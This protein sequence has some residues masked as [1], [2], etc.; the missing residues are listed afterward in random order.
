MRPPVEAARAAQPPDAPALARLLAAAR[1]DLRVDRAGKRC[2]SGVLARAAS[3][4]DLAA[5][6]D[7]PDHAVLVGTLDEQPVGFALLRLR[8]DGPPR[9]A[10]VEAIFVEPAARELG[11]GEALLE[12]CVERARAAGCDSIDALALPGSRSLKNLLERAHFR[13]RLLVLERELADPS[14]SRRPSRAARPEEGR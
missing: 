10:V 7:S 9:T 4:G 3:P 6:L 12:A 8:R 11:V 2:A 5:L 13:A 1:D 14:G